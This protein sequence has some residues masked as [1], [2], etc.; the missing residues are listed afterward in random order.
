MLKPSVHDLTKRCELR[1]GVY[2]ARR[3]EATAPQRLFLHTGCHGQEIAG[4]IALAE[5]MERD[6]KWPNVQMVATF[7]DPRGYKEEGYGFASIDGKESCWPPLWGYRMDGRGYWSFY[8]RNSLWGNTDLETVP[9]SHLAERV[10]MGAFE[11]TF[12]L[13]LHE[14]VRSEV[15]RDLFWAGAGILV[16]ETW[17]VSAAEILAA[18]G[19]VSSLTAVA[20]NLIWRWI[21]SALGRPGYIQAASALKDNPFYQTVSDI[22]SQYERSGWSLTGNKWMKYL[23]M[24]MRTDIFVGPGRIL[25]GPSMAQAEWYTI[26]DYALSRFGCPG[27]TT[28]S[29][30]TGAVGLRGIEERVAR[31]LAFVEAT[32]DILDRSAA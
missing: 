7:S 2:F 14:T 13:S 32:L 1:D 5:L 10:E 18:R 30:P 9:L 27:I 16:L 17:P 3:G 25:H 26:M 24:S 21:E 19:G 6:W 22:V 12:V 23:E 31:Q 15:E 11:P 8:D 28:E 4:P 20:L 29:F